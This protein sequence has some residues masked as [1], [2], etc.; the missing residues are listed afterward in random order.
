MEFPNPDNLLRFQVKVKP[1]DGYWN[2]A[3]YIFNVECPG[4]YPISPPKVTCQTKIYHPNINLE[5]NVCLNILKE[6][7]KPTFGIEKVIIGLLHLFNEP[8]GNDPL[9]HE[10]AALLRQDQ[11]QFGRVV[12]KTLRG[13]IVDGVNFPRLL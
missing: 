2:G 9:N 6:D 10:A 4:D 13:G 12:A 1:N 7:W 5:G 11:N 8:N 3:T